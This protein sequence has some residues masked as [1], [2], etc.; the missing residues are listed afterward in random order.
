M[1]QAIAS[2]YA[3]ALADAVL[4][5]KNNA[6]ARA[7]SGELGAFEHV[8]AESP[9]LKSA[10]LSPAVPPGRK[11]AVVSRFAGVLSLS[12]LVR[13]FLFLLIDRRRIDLIA[14]IR[15]AFETELD[16]RMGIIRADIR[17]AA[18]L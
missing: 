18:S 1:P 5:P 9:E 12:R 8:L 14:E 11:R 13:N 15:Q 3:R 4:D 17:S 10:L 6:D 16:A 2:R 7:T